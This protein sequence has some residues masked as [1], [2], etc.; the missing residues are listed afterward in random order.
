MGNVRSFLRASD[1]RRAEIE[2]LFRVS[3]ELKA[4]RKKRLR[5]DTLA[6]RSIALYLEKASVRTRVSFSV[7]V[8]ELGADIVELTGTQTKVGS[9]EHPFDFAAVIARYCDALVARVFS[10]EALDEMARGGGIPVVNALSD[11]HHPCQAVADYFTLSE[12]FGSLEGLTLAYVGDGNNNVTHSLLELGKTLGVKVR[13]AS[14][15]GY[16]PDAKIAEGAV[17]VNDPREAVEGAHAVYTDTWTSMGREAEKAARRAALSEYKVDDALLA[18]AEKDAVVMHCL[19]A[20]RGE[21]LEA[22]MIH[23]PR[24][25]ILDEAENRL[26]TQKAILLWLLADG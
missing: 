18:L 21:E 16:E 22:D 26:H 14:P 23:G 3:A 25:V 15:K 11:G 4:E 13:V 9:G 7:G 2:S 8:R 12:R 17:V 1:L 5:R 19:P 24:S 10:D 6:G 20:V